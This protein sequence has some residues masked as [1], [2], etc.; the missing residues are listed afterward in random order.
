MA[1]SDDQGPPPEGI[2]ILKGGLEGEMFVV[3]EVL[4]FYQRKIKLLGHNQAVNLSHHV[5]KHDMLQ[6]AKLLLKKLWE[7]RKCTASS[8][9][10]YV[11]KSLDERRSR[12]G[13]NVRIAQDIINFLHLED[14]NL[15]I[16]FLTLKCE[17]IPSI[18][19]ESEAMQDV[20]PLLH[21]NEQD[22][23]NVMELLNQK[24]Y[25]VDNYANMVT[26]LILCGIK[27]IPPT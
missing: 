24:N 13:A 15:N 8:G 16:I 26:D 9:N 18:I 22:Y 10:E 17:D 21:K 25:L 2:S 14:L 11:I 27:D 1:G 12:S 5:F 20:Y 23:D 3:N 7:W 4:N 19:H 6:E